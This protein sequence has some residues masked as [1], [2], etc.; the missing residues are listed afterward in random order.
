[1]KELE[2]LPLKTI[3][4]SEGVVYVLYQAAIFKNAPHPN[5]ARLLMDFLLSEEA[6]SIYARDGYGPVVAGASGASTP[7]LLG[8]SELATAAEMAGFAKEIY[9]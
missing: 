3:V 5:A 8:T 2:G 4:P 9:Q 1:M 7:P 6:Q